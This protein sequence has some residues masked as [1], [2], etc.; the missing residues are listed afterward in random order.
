[1]SRFSFL[2]VS[3]PA[4]V[5]Y[6]I[7]SLIYWSGMLAPAQRFL[8]DVSWFTL[9]KP[10]SSDIVLVQLDA[11]TLREEST[12]PWPRRYHADVTRKVAEAG[13]RRLFLYF[14][15]ST[16]STPEADQEFEDVLKTE[17]DGRV[18]LPAF[19]KYRESQNGLESGLVFPTSRFRE[20]VTVVS[21]NFLLESDALARKFVLSD[22]GH[23]PPLPSAAAILNGWVDPPAEAL[24]L[25]FSIIPDSFQ[26]LSYIDVLQGKYD[27]QTFK[28]KLVII[29]ATANKLGELIPTSTF[30]QLISGETARKL[31]EFV[32]VPR[33]R[34]LPAPLVHAIAYESIKRGPLTV[35]PSWTIMFGCML[36]A[37]LLGRVF[38]AVTWRWGL[39]IVVGTIAAGFLGSLAGISLVRGIADLTPFY[40]VVLLS[41]FLTILA[42]LDQQTLR[43]W[44]QKIELTRKDVI[45]RNIVNTS[46]DAIITVNEN[47]AVEVSN[48]A[49]EQMFG[50]GAK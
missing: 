9:Q 12:F 28:D 18:L 10:V 45:L 4:L 2:K 16:E 30:E 36:S 15:F 5:A 29:G 7:T 14:D 11:K 25:D 44:L 42:K 49:A 40:V 20:H 3:G 43:L 22:P 23:V 38:N 46:T 13:A 37:L 6:T 1:M 47:G 19:S 26:R 41:F 24:S 21:T 17:A 32:P 35:V 34:S 31:G 48:P 8:T 50:Y 33:F 39:L 27:P